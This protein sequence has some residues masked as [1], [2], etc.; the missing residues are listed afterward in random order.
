VDRARPV[1]GPELREYFLGRIDMAHLK[2][3]SE[4][5]VPCADASTPRRTS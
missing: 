1:I 4:N 5:T 2:I 3:S